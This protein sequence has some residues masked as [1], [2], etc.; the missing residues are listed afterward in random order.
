MSD[1][2]LIGERG[3]GKAFGDFEPQSVP[4]RGEMIILAAHLPRHLRGNIVETDRK[5]FRRFGGSGDQGQDMRVDA[6]EY[7]IQLR[8]VALR[9]LVEILKRDAHAG[10]QVGIGL[11]DINDVEQIAA[12]HFLAHVGNDLQ[13]A[14]VIV[15]NLLVGRKR[16]ADIDGTGV[17]LTRIPADER[18]HF[19]HE[20]FH[21]PGANQYQCLTNI[22]V[23]QTV[24]HGWPAT[25]YRPAPCVWIPSAP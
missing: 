23:L 7:I 2:L 10:G 8:I 19:L 1:K 4:E 25:L 22:S 12:A 14:V 15:Q 13:G 3:Q 5:P 6:V 24:L 16:H 11:A 21:G 17:A 9:E 20:C 18:A